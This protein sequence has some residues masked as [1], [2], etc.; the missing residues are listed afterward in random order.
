M[1]ASCGGAPAQ[2]QARYTGAVTPDGPCGAASSGTLTTLIAGG[3]RGHFTFAPADGVLQLSGTVGEDG[4][5]AAELTTPGADRKGFTM[6]F[7]GHL[8]PEHVTGRYVTPR[9]GFSVS[10]TNTHARA[11]EVPYL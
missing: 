9:C 5:L 1:L 2:Q 3:A 7:S 10:L 4:T 8:D 11:F 6:R